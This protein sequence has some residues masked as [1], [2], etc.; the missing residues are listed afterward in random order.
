MDVNEIKAEEIRE[1]IKENGFKKYFESLYEGEPDYND[2][3][4]K[5]DF[6]YTVAC[7]TLFDIAELMNMLAVSEEE[8]A[9]K[10]ITSLFEPT[11]SQ[12]VL[13]LQTLFDVG[14][15][16]TEK[17]ENLTEEEFKQH[18]DIKQDLI[19]GAAVVSDR[20]LTILNIMISCQISNELVDAILNDIAELYCIGTDLGLIKE[21]EGGE[22]D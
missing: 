15:S 20:V 13:D 10:E 9:L 17:R 18:Q 7:S 8:G 12:T 22:D 19:K 2:E 6:G 5:L 16:M 14:I 3:Q 4:T 21:E 1:F 11:I